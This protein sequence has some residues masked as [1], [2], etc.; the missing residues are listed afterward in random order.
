MRIP[1][2]DARMMKRERQVLKLE[3]KILGIQSDLGSPTFHRAPLIFRIRTSVLPEL[4]YLR[5]CKWQQK[6]SNFISRCLTAWHHAQRSFAVCRDHSFWNARVFYN[7]QNITSVILPS[8]L[9]FLVVDTRVRN[10]KIH[11]ACPVSEDADANG[12]VVY[13]PLHIFVHRSQFRVLVTHG[14]S[15]LFFLIES[16]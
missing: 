1:N 2:S 10:S 16:G 3:K 9:Y 15:N 11:T 14:T 4:F 6:N 8:F 12:T 13:R 5:K 7:K